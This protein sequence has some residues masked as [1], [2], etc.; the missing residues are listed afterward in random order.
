MQRLP[1]VQEAKDMMKEAM[2]WSAFKWLFEKSR[3]R[4]TADQANAALDDL[5]R[6]TKAR[7]S[8]EIK[9]A[10]KKLSGKAG[11]PKHEKGQQEPAATEIEVL[12]EKV[13]AAD[14]AAHR[15]RILAEEIFDEAEKQMSTSLAKQGCQ[16]AIYSWVLHEK[17]IRSAEALKGKHN[18]P[19]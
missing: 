8:D 9:A 7:W 12:L 19:E 17:A 3:V 18:P 11:G 10:Y 4:R 1:E 13:I 16:K 6:S 14:R 15:A 2:E 5:N